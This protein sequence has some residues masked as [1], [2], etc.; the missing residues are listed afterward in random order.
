M[1]LFLKARPYQRQARKR[2]RPRLT[3]ALSLL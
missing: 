3:D 1:N 2:R